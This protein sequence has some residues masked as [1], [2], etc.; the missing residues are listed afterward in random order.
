MILNTSGKIHFSPM[1]NH[2]FVIF[3]YRPL[4]YLTKTNDC[5]HKCSNSNNPSCDHCGLIEDYLHLFTKC[6]RIQK[7]WK[8]CKPY[9]TK[10]TSQTYTPQQ[11]TLTLTIKMQSICNFLGSNGVHI[12]DIVNCYSTNIN[13]MLNSRKEGGV[14]KTSELI[15]S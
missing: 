2:S 8:H 13:G 5:T 7:I 3:T 6:I 9:L 14:C 1:V 15:L 10:L 4:H 11:H 12:S